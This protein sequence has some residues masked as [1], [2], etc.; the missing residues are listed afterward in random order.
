MLYKMNAYGYINSRSMAEFSKDC[1]DNKPNL[2]PQSVLHNIRKFGD[3]YIYNDYWIQDIVKIM[4]PTEILI[5]YPIEDY[6]MLKICNQYQSQVYFLQWC[7]VNH[8]AP[9]KHVNLKRFI[10]EVR[11]IWQKN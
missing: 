8:L 3:D 6:Y 10:N 9:N 1:I 2:F 7:D 11:I 4:K 5:V